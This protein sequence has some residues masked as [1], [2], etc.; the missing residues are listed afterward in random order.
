MHYPT[1]V[2]IMAM[3]DPIQDDDDDDD[4]DDDGNTL[5]WIAYD[6]NGYEIGRTVYSGN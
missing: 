5:L 3:L 2:N 6:A 1:G 4:D